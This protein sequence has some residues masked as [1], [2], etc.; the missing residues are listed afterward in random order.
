MIICGVWG[1]GREEDGVASWT[2]QRPKGHMHD[3]WNGMGG[4]S[5]SP[6]PQDPIVPTLIDVPAWALRRH[7]DRLVVGD[8]LFLVESVEDLGY[9]TRVRDASGIVRREP[10]KG[11]TVKIQIG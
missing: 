9:A 10:G 8:A 3:G 11:E 6:R 5:P 7:V 1:G 2:C 4:H